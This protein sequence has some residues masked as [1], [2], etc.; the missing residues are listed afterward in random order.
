MVTDATN[1]TMVPLMWLAVLTFNAGM[2]PTLLVLLTYLKRACHRSLAVLS[3]NLRGS[4]MPSLSSDPT[5]LI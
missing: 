3:I 1:A 5:K 4:L 2:S